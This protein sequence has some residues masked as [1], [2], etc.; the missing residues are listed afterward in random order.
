MAQLWFRMVGIVSQI[1]AVNRD[2]GFTLIEVLIA[3]SVLSIGLLALGALQLHGIRG[4]ALGQ[5]RSLAVALAEDR[6]EAFLNTPYSD[7]AEG[8]VTEDNVGGDVFT[9]TSVVDN[10]TPTT[11]MKTIRVFVEWHDIADH[12]VHF[13]T[14]MAENG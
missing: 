1:K 13:R 3:I 2:R 4:N 10:N 14:I 5:K 8:S 11:G 9:R 6:I 12:E 7:I